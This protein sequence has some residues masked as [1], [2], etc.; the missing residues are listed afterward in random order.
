MVLLYLILLLCI[1]SAQSALQLVAIDTTLRTYLD[2]VA[3]PPS[4]PWTPTQY[5]WPLLAQWENATTYTAVR[6]LMF[7]PGDTLSEAQI[8]AL[9]PRAALGKCLPITAA[10]CNAQAPPADAT[11]SIQC[12]LD[13]AGRLASPEAPMDV[14]V[15][16]GTWIT[17]AVL[18]VP[19][20]VRLRGVGASTLLAT[21][22]TSSAVHLSGNRSGAL[23]LRLSSPN[24]T[25]RLSTPQACGVWVGAASGDSAVADTL[26]LGV[27]VATPA[28]AHVFGLG[29][30][31]GIWAFNYAHDGF[32]DT[33]HHTGGSSACQIVGNRASGPGTRGDDLFAFVGYASDGDPVH[34]CAAIANYGRHGAARG[35]AAVGAGF[36]DFS[37][38]DI[39]WTQWAGVYIAQEDGY[40]T[41]GS[42]DVF[43]RENS[44]MDS[45]LNG[46]HDGLLAYSDSP[47][48][49]TPSFSFGLVPHR[50][51]RLLVTNNTISDTARGIGN[52]FGIEIRGSVNAGNVSCNTLTRNRQPQLVCDGTNFSQCT[53]A[54]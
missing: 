5:G 46:S 3:I 40:D 6:S 15:P 49:N 12:A 32:A 37:H 20:D 47:A 31:G 34:H 22:P 52:G 36:I 8:T 39:A 30:V 27:E 24:S 28:A 4:G 16:N 26:V 29:E 19:Q 13:A 44:V 1:A 50:I 18:E 51:E 41:Y 38:N 9:L 43:V 42:F 33:F 2:L 14:L 23:F 17:S 45:N 48:E 53:V 25:S 7:N 21:D 11:L 35:L 54:C 10:P